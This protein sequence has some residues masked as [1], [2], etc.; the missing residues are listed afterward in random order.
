MGQK[1]VIPGRFM[2]STH[3]AAI[4]FAAKLE[5]NCN[6]LA[7]WP[8]SEPSCLVAGVDQEEAQEEVSRPKGMHLAQL[9]KFGELSEL[10]IQKQ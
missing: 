2:D 1:I 4:F 6:E 5:V 9:L 10:Q 8:P 3:E 7:S